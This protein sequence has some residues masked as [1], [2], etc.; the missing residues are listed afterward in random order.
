MEKNT[1]ILLGIGAAIAAYLILKPKKETQKVVESNQKP[2]NDRLHGSC[3]QGY[4]Y[5]SL[6]GCLPN[7]ILNPKNDSPCMCIKAPC[8]C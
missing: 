4:T 8:N 5:N 7:S 2:E 1:K 3:P 6:A